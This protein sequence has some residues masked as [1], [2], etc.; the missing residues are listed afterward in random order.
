MGSHQEVHGITSITYDT[1][2]RSHQETHGI[3]SNHTI[4]MSHQPTIDLSCIPISCQYTTNHPNMFHTYIHTKLINSSL[5][6][7]YRTYKA[8]CINFPQQ[9]VIQSF[10]AY[11]H[12]INSTNLARAKELS[13]RRE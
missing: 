11:M 12:P 13:L 8:S 1:T 6:I 3:T 7:S 5:I 10:E 2:M 9:Q 4:A